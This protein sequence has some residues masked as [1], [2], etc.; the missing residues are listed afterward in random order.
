MDRCREIERERETERDWVIRRGCYVHYICLLLLIESRVC[1]C[2]LAV[3]ASTAR[4]GPCMRAHARKASYERL[5]ALPEGG[6]SPAN[7]GLLLAMESTRSR[8]NLLLA[9]GDWTGSRSEVFQ[10][11]SPLFFLFLFFFL[12]SYNFFVHRQRTDAA[13]AE[14]GAGQ[15]LRQ[16]PAEHDSSV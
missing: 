4:T 16:Q 1:V 5:A 10:A 2:L 14:A 6:C 13:H 12:P 15:L 8:G 3:L 9:V 11:S 7:Q